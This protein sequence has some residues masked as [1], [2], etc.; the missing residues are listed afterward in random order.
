MSPSL[1]R[2]LASAIGGVAVGAVVLTAGLT[3]GLVR[4]TGD[5]A[6]L[7][8]LRL[9]ADR[10][11]HRP[12]VL[13]AGPRGP[14]GVFVSLGA[15]FVPDGVDHPYAGLDQPEGR[16]EVDGQEV[17]YVA[18]RVAVRQSAGTLYV[19][20][21]AE[22]SRGLGSHVARRVLVASL[23][24]LAA[25]AAVA[26][27]LSRRISQPLSQLAGAAVGLARGS[28][29]APE[30]LAAQDGEPSEVAD[31]RAAFAGMSTGLAAAR[32]RERTFLLSVSHELRTPLTSIRGYA[33]ALADAAAPDPAAAGRVVLDESRR[34]ERLV[35]D[36][37]DL[38]RLQSGEFPVEVEEADLAAVGARVVESLR[39]LASQAEVM[40]EH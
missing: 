1:R 31:L 27:L 3:L 13:R 30:A 36:L 11:A 24:A 39:P 10:M 7:A 4:A 29:P 12:G 2:V 5:Q 25:S 18:R 26:Y 6:T 8:E 20:R 38:A 9:Q 19:V 28:P 14:E 22:G 37:M 40:L 32:E 33:E 34:L 17:L 23:I 21:L 35:G 15:E 16:G